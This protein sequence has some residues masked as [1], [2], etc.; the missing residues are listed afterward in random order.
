[1][2]PSVLP[3]KKWSHVKQ[4]ATHGSCKLFFTFPLCI[5]HTFLCPSLGQAYSTRALNYQIEASLLF[6]TSVSEIDQHNCDAM[7]LFSGLSMFHEVCMLQLQDTTPTALQDDDIIGELLRIFTLIRNLVR[8]WIPCFLCIMNG[9]ITILL[10]KP[11]RADG[12]ARVA[13]HVYLA[14]SKL[15]VLNQI[16]ITQINDKVAYSTVI[17]LLANISELVVTYPDGWSPI[18]R[19]AF[20]LPE[21]YIQLLRNR[22]QFAMVILA[23]YCVIVHHS[24]NWWCMLGWSEKVF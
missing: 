23:H 11:G 5:L 2:S 14:L 15:E 3:V 19:W 13:E 6:R 20:H 1:M 12:D 10:V 18:M 21:R 24:Q 16:V 7:V 4:F 9:R 22:E 17:R 8:I